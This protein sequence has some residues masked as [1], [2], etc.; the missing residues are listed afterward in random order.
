MMT[1]GAPLVSLADCGHE[2]T[3]VDVCFAAVRSLA[4]IGRLP[5]VVGNN[6]NVAVF[7]DGIYS[8]QGA[9]LCQRASDS[10]DSALRRP[11]RFRKSDYDLEVG[12]GLKQ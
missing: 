1:C 5:L 9:D 11:D 2:P 10:E 12:V 4:S 7:G 8:P 6:V 3:V